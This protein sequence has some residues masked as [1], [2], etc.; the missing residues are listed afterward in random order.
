[1]LFKLLRK[2]E[3]EGTV[4]FEFLPGKYQDKC[5]NNHSVYIEEEALCVISDILLKT[6][7]DYDHY[8]F[9]NYN[10]IQMKMLE[11]ELSKRLTEIKDN[12]DYKLTGKYFNEEYY[13]ELNEYMK[14]YRIEIIKMLEELIIWIKSIKEPEMMVLGL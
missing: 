2:N 9:T 13:N 12:I 11:N 4:Y 1:M 6:N 14:K 8:L 5:W 3:L 7:N 10:S